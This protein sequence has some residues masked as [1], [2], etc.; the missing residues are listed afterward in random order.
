MLLLRID[1]LNLLCVCTCV[2][3]CGSHACTWPGEPE[4]FHR[5]PSIVVTGGRELP[6][7]HGCWER[8]LGCSRAARTQLLSHAPGPDSRLLTPHCYQPCFYI[9]DIDVCYLYDLLLYILSNFISC[10]FTSLSM[11][12]KRFYSLIFFF[13]TGSHSV[14]QAGLEDSLRYSYLSL[15]SAGI[16]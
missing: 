7:R 16:I 15:L 3:E 4:E 10:L 6:R 13:E 5:S 8:S 2:N 9:P 14:V 11:P 12:I 1:L